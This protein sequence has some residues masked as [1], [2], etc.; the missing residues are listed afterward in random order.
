MQIINYCEIPNHQF[1]IATFDIAFDKEES[2]Y[3]CQSKQWKVCRTKSGG[4]FIKG[5]SFK[6]GNFE[7]KDQ[8]EQLNMLRGDYSKEFVQKIMELLKPYIAK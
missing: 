2:R 3:I 5:K 4:H 8:Y 7:G 1:D 6:A